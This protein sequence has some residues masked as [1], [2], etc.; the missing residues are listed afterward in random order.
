MQ[1][2]GPSGQQRSCSGQGGAGVLG[3]PSEAISRAENHL[4]ALNHVLIIQMM[5]DAGLICIG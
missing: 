4:L 5:D 3:T 1:V 2:S